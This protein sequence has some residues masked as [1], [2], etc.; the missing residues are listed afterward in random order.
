[1]FPTL[2]AALA[3]F[4][5]LVVPELRRRGLFRQEYEGPT[6]RHNL[7]LARPVHRRV[8]SATSL[9]AII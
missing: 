9:G 4:T 1:M 2:P 8:A 6:L 7:G 5:E 3:D